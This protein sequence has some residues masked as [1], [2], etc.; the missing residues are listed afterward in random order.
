MRQIWN[1]GVLEH[2]DQETLSSDN[3]K[4]WEVEQR[5]DLLE[6]FCGNT[7]ALGP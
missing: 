1:E 3:S 5:Q 7:I 4:A 2:L 6:V